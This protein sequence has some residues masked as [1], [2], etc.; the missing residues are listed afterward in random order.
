MNS[1]L[2]EFTIGPLHLL[3]CVIQIN[4]NNNYMHAC[5]ENGEWELKVSQA[6]TEDDLLEHQ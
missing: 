6:Q 1:N 4:N 3:W 5:L 2:L